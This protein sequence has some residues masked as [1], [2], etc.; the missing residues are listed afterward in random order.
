MY[1]YPRRA[2]W[3]PAHKGPGGPQGL[4]WPT[5][6]RPTKA[7]GGPTRARRTTDQTDIKVRTRL[8]LAQHPRNKP[9]WLYVFDSTK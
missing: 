9:V 1:I 2:H 6:A 5:R 4:S 3:G 7:Q 8:Y